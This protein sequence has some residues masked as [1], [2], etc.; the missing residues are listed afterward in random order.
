MTDPSSNSSL[1]IIPE[2]KIDVDTSATLHGF[3]LT[4]GIA[5]F[6]GAFIVVLFSI[7]R[8]KEKRFFAPRFYPLKESPGNRLNPPHERH[9]FS[10]ISYTLNHSETRL[11]HI[12]GFDAVMYLRFLKYSI[13]LFGVLSLIST[14]F[15]MPINVTAENKSKST[16]DAEFVVGLNTFSL[17][18]IPTGS[19]RFWAHLL[20]VFV[21]S[22]LVYYYIWRLHLSHVQLDDLSKTSATSRSIQSRTVMVTNLPDSCI[23]DEALVACFAEL[24]GTKSILHATLVPYV[25]ELSHLKEMRNSYLK[26]LQSAREAYDE[27]K[28][29]KRPTHR[30]GFLCF[31]PKV[32]SL[33]FYQDQVD[34]LETAIEMQ[35]KKVLPPTNIGFI[36][37]TSVRTAMQAAQSLHDKD[38][39]CMIVEPAPEPNDINWKWLTLRRAEVHTRRIVIYTFIALLFFFWTFPIT[40]VS[41]FANLSTLSKIQGLSFLVRALSYNSVIKGLVEGFLPSL[42]LL[43]FLVIL[44]YILRA[45]LHQRGLR[46][47][48]EFDRQLVRL[49]W[50][51]LLLNVF[52]VS[53]F[54]GT[55]FEVFARVLEHPQY[56]VSVLATSLPAQALY[57]TNYIVLQGYAGYPIFWLFRLDEYLIC[58]FMQ[59]FICKTAREKKEAEEPMPLFYSLL[60]ARELLIFSIALSYSSM[61]PLMLPFATLYFAIAYL[62]AKHNFVYVFTPHHEGNRMTRLVIHCVMVGIL[63]YQATMMG[64]LGLKLFPYAAALLIAMTMTVVVWYYWQSVYSRSLSVLALRDC[65][66]TELDI[67][68]MDERQIQHIRRMYTHPA[69]L[70]PLLEYEASI[71]VDPEK[72]EQEPVSLDEILEEEAVRKEPSNSIELEEGELSNPFTRKTSPFDIEENFE[73][74]HRG[75]LPGRDNP[76][77]VRSSSYTQISNVHKS[78]SD[79]DLLSL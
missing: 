53:V 79:P 75:S 70:S 22:L 19:S 62:T 72:H 58:K 3:E 10:W 26:K 14:A 61:V 63:I 16:D 23:N 38:P 56:I 60:Y 71:V 42:A 31:G 44:P 45:I 24:Y 59:M 33:T 18:N 64:V 46:L 11:L 12:A 57:F 4:L 13:I 30:I 36:T 40:F 34:A 37:F 7:L 52:L 28:D 5:T 25:E 73:V 65:P 78:S 39:R 47:H 17:A 35:K 8:L 32:D 15:L 9:I 54:A 2:V 41:A 21:F 55:F 27:S 48:S 67:H 50:L 66:G 6:V 69:L 29:K 68:S 43:L 49:Y 20:S 51:F 77:V 74:S 1:I 76:Q